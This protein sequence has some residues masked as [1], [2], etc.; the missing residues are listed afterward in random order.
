[1][2]ANAVEN[3]NLKVWCEYFQIRFALNQGKIASDG[4]IYH[5]ENESRQAAE[6]FPS[7]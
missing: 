5:F 2:R 4:K 3:G 7:G 6:F 1:M